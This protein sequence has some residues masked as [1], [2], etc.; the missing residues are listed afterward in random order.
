MTQPAIVITP[1]LIELDCI[2]IMIMGGLAAST[3]SRRPSVYC[4][5]FSLF[6]VDGWGFIVYH[7]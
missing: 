6:T 1:L 5:Y 3:H 2:A 7:Q 4:I